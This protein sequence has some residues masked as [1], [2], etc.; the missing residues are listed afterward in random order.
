MFV[1][2]YVAGLASFAVILVARDGGELWVFTFIALVVVV[3]VG[4]YASG[5][6]FGRHPDGLW[7]QR[8]VRSIL[9]ARAGGSSRPRCPKTE[10]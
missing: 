9:T 1:Q 7:R 10:A 8:G 6:T 2:A 4:A 5:L 3:D